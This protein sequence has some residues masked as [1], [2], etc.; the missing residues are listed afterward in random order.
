MSMKRGLPER[1]SMRHDAHFVEELTRR[2]GRHIGSMIPIELIE[3]NAEQP[4]TQL[5]NIEELAASIKEKGV[6]EPILVRNAGPNRYQIIS[7]ERR[8]RAA[9]LAGLDEIPAIE[10][11]VDDKEQLEI[12]LIENIQRKDLTAFEEAEGFLALQQKFGYTHEKISHVIGKSRTT[13]TETL[14]LNDI[15]DRIRAMCRE[16]GISS[17]ST[18]VQIARAGDEPAMEEIVRRFA[19]GESTRDEVRKQTAKPEPKKAG[20]PKNFT[21]QVKDKAL[22]FS[23]N[24]SFRKANVDK[25]EIVS[26]LRE[27][28]RRVESE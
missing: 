7:G 15:P 3:P 4:R 12:A 13:I 22:P 23:V 21:W 26:A 19:A 10:L 27:L 17:K 25:G 18:L 5:G 20:R 28:L 11:D 24:L 9:S 8:F 1:S 2:S 14:S 6:L 16:A